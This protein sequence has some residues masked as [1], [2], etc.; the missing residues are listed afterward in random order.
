MKSVM[1]ESLL[2]RSGDIAPYTPVEK[3][4]QGQP[5]AVSKV[6]Q[7]SLRLTERVLDVNPGQ[8]RCHAEGEQRVDGSQEK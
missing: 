4:G 7:M 2:P 6:N 5:E 1:A 8:E 3:P